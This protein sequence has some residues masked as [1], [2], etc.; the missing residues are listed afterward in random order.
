M[1]AMLAESSVGAQPNRRSSARPGVQSAASPEPARHDARTRPDGDHDRRRSPQD[2]RTSPATRRRRP[3]CATRSPTPTPRRRS[4][5]RCCAA[6]AGRAASTASMPVRRRHR[7]GSGR[8]RRR[9]ARRHDRRRAQ[10]RR[11]SD[12][13]DAA[14]KFQEPHRCGRAQFA[15]DSDALE[16]AR[17]LQPE[18][19][20]ASRCWRTTQPRTAD[21]RQRVSAPAARQHVVHGRRQRHRHAADQL[22]RRASKKTSPRIST[23]GRRRALQQSRRDGAVQSETARD[24]RRASTTRI[25]RRSTRTATSTSRAASSSSAASATSCT[26]AGARCSVSSC[27]FDP[28]RR[29]PAAAGLP[30]RRLPA[31][32]AQRLRL[33]PG[34]RAP[35]IDRFI[36]L[37]RRRSPTTSRTGSCWRRRARRSRR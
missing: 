36:D 9:R 13:R 1:F 16:R 23:V 20:S 7:R 17:H 32:R 35:D 19:D 31:H 27:S 11:E 2:L 18:F 24:S 33:H 3:N 15:G 14:G 26:A 28:D 6:S 12:R 5:I 34:S 10:R 21:R 29:Q 22:E 37:L 8:A 30:L 25:S 4:S